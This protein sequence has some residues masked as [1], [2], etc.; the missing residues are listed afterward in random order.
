MGGIIDGRSGS[1][2]APSEV[3]FGPGGVQMRLVLCK[4]AIKYCLNGINNLT[5]GTDKTLNIAN[6]YNTIIKQVN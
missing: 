1:I 5:V 4:E 3:G 6:F 2:L